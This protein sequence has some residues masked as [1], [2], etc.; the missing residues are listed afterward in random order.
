[1]LYAYKL[2]KFNSAKF[3]VKIESKKLFYFLYLKTFPK[4]DLILKSDVLKALFILFRLKP[5]H[6]DVQKKKSF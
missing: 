1:M 2:I 6:E 3:G 5:D 4:R